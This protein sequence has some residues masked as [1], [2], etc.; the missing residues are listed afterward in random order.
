MTLSAT[1][2]S[3]S[4]SFKFLHPSFHSYTRAHPIFPLRNL[5]TPFRGTQSKRTLLTK[6]L[7]REECGEEWIRDVE[8]PFV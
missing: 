6:D 7:V 2:P 4:T 3:V 5:M 8:V 1:W